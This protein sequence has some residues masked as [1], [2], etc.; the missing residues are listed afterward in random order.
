MHRDIDRDLHPHR[1]GS[2]WDAYLHAHTHGQVSRP[3]VSM[4]VSAAVVELMVAMLH[5]PLG[6]LAPVEGGTPAEDSP[7]P[8]SSCLGSVP[9]QVRGFVADFR[10]MCV[11]VGSHVW[12]SYVDFA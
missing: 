12:I 2:H 7:E 9:H 3:G 6:A 4:M 11:G 10:Q 5:H 8:G 1:H